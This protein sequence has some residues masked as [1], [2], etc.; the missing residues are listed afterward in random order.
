MALHLPI[1]YTVGV[2]FRRLNSPLRKQKETIG[3][4]GAVCEG[5]SVV[6][7]KRARERRRHRRLSL[8]VPVFAKGIDEQGKEFLEFTSTLNI[9]AT[10]ALLAVRRHLAAG[11]LITLEIPSAPLPHLAACPEPVRT[12]DAQ[13]VRLSL[14][15]P[16]YLC[17]V[18][19]SH[20]LV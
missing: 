4:Q 12:L 1:Y 3:L 7:R 20:P 9:S 10:G 15:Q 14:A 11:S 17:A 6:S 16:P 8:G 19:F 5:V 13:I 18:S 2:K